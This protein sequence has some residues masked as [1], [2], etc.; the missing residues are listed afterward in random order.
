MCRYR[1]HIG[2]MPINF[3]QFFEVVDP[4]VHCGVAHGAPTNSEELKQ[5]LNSPVEMLKIQK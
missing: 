4:C 2:S 3:A 5:M 1:W